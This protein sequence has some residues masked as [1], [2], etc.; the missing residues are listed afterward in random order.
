MVG[1]RTWRAARD[2]LAGSDRIAV[3]APVESEIARLASYVWLHPFVQEE[4]LAADL[5]KASEAARRL[6]IPTKE[7]LRLVH[8]T[9]DS[10]RDGEGNRVRPRRSDR[11]VSRQDILSRITPPDPSVGE[12][13]QLQQAADEAS[14]P[15]LTRIRMGCSIGFALRARAVAA[16]P[17]CCLAWS[18]QFLS[19][20]RDMPGE[21]SL[22]EGAL[23]IRLDFEAELGLMICKRTSVND[24]G[25]TNGRR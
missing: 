11:G 20:R 8:E 15:I 7:L 10:L 18:V 2:A 16:S 14:L 3:V 12:Y 5:L 24:E 13:G 1:G 21:R 17:I 25:T 19:G 9:E 22:P 6:G 23:S 4:E